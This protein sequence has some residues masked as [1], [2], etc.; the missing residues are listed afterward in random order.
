MFDMKQV[1]INISNLR[2]AAGFTQMEMADKLGI[3]FQAVSNLERGISMPDISK[4]GE[5][6]AIFHVSVD[7]ILDCKR[8]GEIARN[9]LENRPILDIRTNEINE[10]A[11]ILHEEQV[12]TLLN[13]ADKSNIKH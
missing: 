5:L 1:G 10:I 12:E 13:N 2:K 6:S 9:L 3:S 8:T 4:L 7:E 11:P